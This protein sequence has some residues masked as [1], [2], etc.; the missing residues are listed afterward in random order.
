MQNL[1]ARTHLD[2]VSIKVVGPEDPIAEKSHS[3][4]TEGVG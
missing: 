3:V 4:R 1:P 2:P